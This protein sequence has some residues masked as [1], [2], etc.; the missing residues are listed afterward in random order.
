MDPAPRSRAIALSLVGAALFLAATILFAH[1][2]HA[3]LPSRGAKVDLAKGTLLLSA[4]ARDALDVDS[5]LVE[6]ANRPET[7]LAYATLIP[8]WNHHAFATSPLSGRIVSIHARAGQRVEKGALLAEVETQESEILRL[9][10]QN[11]LEERKLASH[12]LAGLKESAGAVAQSSLLAAETQ[13][14]QARDALELARAKWLALGFAPAILED[15]LA[16]KKTG[17]ATL[18]VRSLVA[19][20]V[21]HADIAVGRVVD[22]GEHLFEIV[23]LSTVWA[24]IGVLEKD[25]PRVRVGL[26]VS[27]RLTAHPEKTYR[28]TIKVVGD[29]LDPGSHLND[30]WVHLENPPGQD[31][32]LLPG[33][34]G[35]ARIELP[36]AGGLKSIPTTALINDGLD[37]FVLIE[38]ARAKE[39]SEYRKKSLVVVRETPEW[40]EVKSSDLFPGD[41]VITRGSHQL[42]VFFQSGV[43]KLPPETE[44]SIGLIWAPVEKGPID[45]IVEIAATVDIPAHRRGAASTRVPATILSVRAMPGQ[46]VR[47]GDPLGELF[48]LE[49]LNL[50]LDLL[51]ETLA[52][53]LA[54]EQLDLLQTATDA[55]SR[56]RMVESETTFQQATNRKISLARRLTVMGLSQ[57]EVEALER[58]G[59]IQPTIT[60]RSPMDGT[61]VRLDRVV[62]Q[63]IRV[64]EPVFEIHDL[65]QPL[66]QG[67]VPEKSFSRIQVGQLARIRLVGHETQILEARVARSG[68]TFG[69]MDRVLSVWL[70]P[71]G[72]PPGTLR[73]NQMATAAIILSSEPA[74]QVVPESAL[75]K[76]GTRHYVFVK[77]KDRIQRRLVRTGRGDDRVIEIVEGL[78]PGDVV[79]IRAVEALQTAYASVR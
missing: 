47:A 28:G 5:Q 36:V 39:V 72:S 31:P 8:P 24:R 59:V 25:I 10:I 21:L 62:G 32:Q 48:S 68:D 9:D 13:W 44:K 37:R 79:A 45:S 20:T 42:G 15:L 7:V 26:P 52:T 12:I 57:T 64:D 71:Q 18:P 70:E 66:V 19:G 63:N 22:P 60:L 38:E 74:N 65:S 56:R 17:P 73:H 16:G 40:V 35:E 14:K 46:R 33:M 54:R 4:E 3:P 75:L 1:E 43:F 30:V 58:N 23:D 69:L 41:K 67:F 61:I 34:S 51:R 50:Q 2:G 76:E 11:A 6:D 77:D 53:R 78:D 29:M 27:L 49:I 55:V